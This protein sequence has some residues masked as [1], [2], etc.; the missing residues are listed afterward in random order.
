MGRIKSLLVKRTAK[1]L[2][3]IKPELFTSSFEH[4][5]KILGN[6]MP[7]KPLR[8]KIAG[9]IARLLKIKKSLSPGLLEQAPASS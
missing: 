4:N 5:K 6:N 2:L 3:A 1:Q 8:N 9:Y 7:S